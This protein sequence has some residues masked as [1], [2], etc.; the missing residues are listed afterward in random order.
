LGDGGVRE[1]AHLWPPTPRP[2]LAATPPALGDA[3]DAHAIVDSLPLSPAV[4]AT[5]PGA[6]ADE[7]W[8]AS[9]YGVYD[10]HSGA[11]AAAFL[12]TRLHAAVA[13]HLRAEAVR[14]G[15]AHRGVGLAA[16]RRAL[17]AAFTQTDEELLN[18]GADGDA[19]SCAAVALVCPEHVITAHAGDC[20]VVLWRAGVA[21]PLTADHRAGA[22]AEKA[23]VEAA[24]GFVAYGRVLGQLAVSRSFGDRAFKS[25]DV[26][27]GA[28]A[29]PRI[30]QLVTAA[31]D[32]ACVRWKVGDFLVLA[33]DGVWD[34][35]T[36]QEVRAE[37]SAMRALLPGPRRCCQ[38]ACARSLHVFASLLPRHAAPSAHGPK[39]PNLN[40]RGTSRPA[41]TRRLTLS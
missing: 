4:D 29:E 6:H 23:R 8:R 10:G 24:G 26:S 27:G 16:A 37:G 38:S 31:P 5:S 1:A 2:P 12:R 30:S 41:P 36:D 20:R 9:L 33:C 18:R 28:G 32:V 35:M 7:G 19:G 22:P 21:T 15:A 11:R 40:P 17:D 39:P 3:Q 14:A 25:I 34:V 13:T